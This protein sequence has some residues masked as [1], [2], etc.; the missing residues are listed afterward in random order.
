[1]TSMCLALIFTGRVEAKAVGGTAMLSELLDH[2]G[3]LIR[4]IVRTLANE[5]T[6]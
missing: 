5:R 4:R 2:M 1:M 3:D 6:M